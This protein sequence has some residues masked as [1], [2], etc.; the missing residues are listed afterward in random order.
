MIEVIEAQKG[1]LLNSFILF[2]LELYKN[3]PFYSPFLIKDQKIYF[4]HENPFF[5]PF[6]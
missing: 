6:L 2:P 5:S 1:E 3:D 4:S